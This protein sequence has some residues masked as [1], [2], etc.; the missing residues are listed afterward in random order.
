MISRLKAHI[1]LTECTGRDIWS[2]ETCRERG[3]PEAWIA[4]LA[5]AHESGFERDRD[6]IYHEGQPTNQYHGV[7][8]LRLAR[9]LAEVLGLDLIRARALS[10]DDT[11]E[12]R[13][14]QEAA[15]D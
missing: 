6:T 15:D 3:I 11:S 12:V 14:L 10:V 8:D 9:Q 2:V 7:H 13:L 1:L 4:E 5:D